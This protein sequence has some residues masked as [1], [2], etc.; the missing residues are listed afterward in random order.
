MEINPI[1]Q[2]NK[3]VLQT[4]TRLYMFS[5]AIFNTFLFEDKIFVP[6][7]PMDLK[8]QDN[9]EIEATP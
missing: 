8:S 1:S 6:S 9:I 4:E 5:R 2:T 3:K 7:V